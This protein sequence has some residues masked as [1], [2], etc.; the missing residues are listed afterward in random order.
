MR[1]LMQVHAGDDS[2]HKWHKV[3]S[4]CAEFSR[5]LRATG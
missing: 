3:A 4:L 2:M 1:H 5:A